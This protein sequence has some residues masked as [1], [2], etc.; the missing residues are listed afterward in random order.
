MIALRNSNFLI[1]TYTDT[2]HMLCLKS[3][4]DFFMKIIFKIEYS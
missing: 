2:L 1:I 3:S 4:M